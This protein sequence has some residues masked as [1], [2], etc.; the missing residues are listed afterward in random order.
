MKFIYDKKVDQE[1]QKRLDACNLIFGEKKKT[2]V[3][4]VDEG[5]IKKFK[6]I[7]TFKIDKKFR[8]EI[9]KIFK[10]KL[11][12]NFTCYINSTPYSMDTARGISIS[13]STST[14]IKTICHETNHFMFRKSEYKKIYFPKHDIENAKEIFTIINN[15]YF[16]NIMESQDVGWKI[17]WKERYVFLTHWLKDIQTNKDI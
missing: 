8:Q 11:P 15:I 1:C 9:Y 5:T 7:W 6:K 3:Y 4:L 14:P 2:E 17:F 12:K 13:A 16:Q 10:T